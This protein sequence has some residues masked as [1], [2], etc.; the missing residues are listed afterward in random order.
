M[1]RDYH[2]IPDFVLELLAGKASGLISIGQEQKL[3]QWL[4][5]N[6]Q[7]ALACKELL[8]L[9]RKQHYVNLQKQVNKEQAWNKIRQR[10]HPD[11]TIRR[12]AL[13]WSK[14]A[15]VIL[16]L[17]G[18]AWYLKTTFTTT[19]TKEII[20]ES[21]VPGRN[22][23]AVLILS[24][25]I[26]LVLDNPGD[27]LLKEFG[28]VD[29]RNKPGELLSYDEH[30]NSTITEKTINKLLVPAGTR[31][32]LQLSDG[33]RV[34]M[35]SVS[36]L[37]YPVVFGKSE[38]RI[39]LTGEAFF[40]VTKDNKRPFIIEANGN[41][42]KVLGTSFNVS[43]YES[44]MQMKTTLVEGAVEITSS[45]GQVFKLAPSQ[46]ASINNRN[47]SVVIETV[48]T[49]Y[50]TSWKDGILYFDNLPLIELT[51]RLERWYDVEIHFKSEKAK[52]LH[53]SGA[54]ENSRNIQFLLNL[55]SQTTHVKFEIN[56]KTISVE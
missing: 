47:Q 25:G 51:T 17:T 32:N 40:E 43:A 53:F 38:R 14:V 30:G 13:K 9:L 46:M 56:G 33:T 21:A 52:Q 31:Y 28:G 34:W 37:E 24:N 3:Q 55:I 15:A 35:N 6:P 48:D 45:Q 18:L 5:E 12:L 27:T 50:F 19:A 49:R 44:D 42:I 41:E 7:S 4:S 22:N 8:E 1:E 39:I 2:A 20:A 29:I 54:M 16:F 23:K 11:K 36:Q 26:Q 10:I